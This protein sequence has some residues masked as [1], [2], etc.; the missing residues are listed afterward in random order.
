MKFH[1]YKNL[2]V[3]EDVDV[4]NILISNKI[5]FGEKNGKYFWKG[6]HM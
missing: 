4:D 3:L 1:C 5:F 2:F 6:L